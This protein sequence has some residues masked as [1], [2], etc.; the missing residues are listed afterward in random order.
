[1]KKTL[2]FLLLPLLFCSKTTTAQ[3]SPILNDGFESGSYSPT[4]VTSLP[5]FSV[6]A[7][8]AAVGNYKIVSTGASGHLNG[9]SSSFPNSTPSEVSW[10]IYP[11]GTAFATNYLVLGNNSSTATDCMVFSHWYNSPMGIRFLGTG[12]ASF[13]YP[14]TTGQW[15]FIA[16]KNINY[17]AR[18]FDIYI[19]GTLQQTAFPFRSSTLSDITKVHLYNVFQSTATWDEIKIGNGIALSASTSSVS[20]FGAATGSSTITTSGVSGPYTYSWTGSASTASVA[21]NLAAGLYSVT[22]T[23]GGTCTATQTISVTQPASLTASST[24]T[25][26]TCITPGRASLSASGATPPYNYSWTP[27]GGG[28]SVANNLSGGTYTCIIVDANNCVNN[29]TL[30]ISSNTVAPVLN[31]ALSSSVICAGQSASMSVTGA[32]TYSWSTGATTASITVSPTVT[33]SYSVTG[34]S[35]SNGC[36]TTLPLTL[37]V[38]SCTGIGELSLAEP[39]FRIYPNPTQ[40]IVYVELEQASQVLVCNVLGDVILETGSVEGTQRVNLSKYSDGV[41][42]IKIVNGSMQRSVRVVKY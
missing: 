6:T 24:Q 7:G 4:W 28:S 39:A 37:S 11:Q 25:N 26:A 2:L 33:T 15:Y 1:M 21:A 42:F 36:T 3:C 30:A 34:T 29:H 12:T 20:C 19:N 31:P 32:D 38:S 16:L 23:A 41:Y 22:V 8:A 9:I 40:G 5:D 27:S 10:Y 14:A 13:Q 17:V 18:T 35:T